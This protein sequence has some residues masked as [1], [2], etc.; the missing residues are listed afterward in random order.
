[1]AGDLRS[2]RN[3][4]I[5]LFLDNWNV[6]H[7]TPA[8]PALPAGPYIHVLTMTDANT[9]PKNTQKLPWARFTIQHT[10]TTSRDIAGRR[11]VHVGII[12]AE[13]F[14][15][16]PGDNSPADNHVQILANALVVAFTKHRG[17]VTLRDIGPIERPI[18]EGFA[19][20]NARAAFTWDQFVKLGA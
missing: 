6:A 11:L 20:C 19:Q 4:L 18:N 9:V 10:G 16:R 5:K 17:S 12:V 1:M 8:V 7:L 13:C 2:N 3:E 15:H 14:V